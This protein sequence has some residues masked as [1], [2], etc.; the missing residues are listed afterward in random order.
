MRRGIG[1]MMLLG[2]AA[3]LVASLWMP[4]YRLDRVLAYDPGKL[5]PDSFFS[6][7]ERFQVVD[8]LL[9]AVALAAAVFAV[10]TL[11][12]WRPKRKYALP[13][14]LTLADGVAIVLFRMAHAPELGRIPDVVEYA[15]TVD[16]GSL[17]ALIAAT[18]V[19]LGSWLTAEAR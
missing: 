2:G 15:V 12:G 17:V 19:V 4:W 8:I 1:V 3:A 14:T 16:Y 10:A 18:T 11:R 6:G 7:W 13:I 5:P 9:L